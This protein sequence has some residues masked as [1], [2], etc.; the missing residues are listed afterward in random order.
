MDMIDAEIGHTPRRETDAE[1]RARI[2]WGAEGIAEARADVAA[3]RV[4]DAARVRAWVESP[5]TN[6]PPPVPRSGR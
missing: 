6:E 2:A 3:G 4:V 5:R 1:R